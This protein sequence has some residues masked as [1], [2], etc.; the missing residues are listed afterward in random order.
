MKMFTEVFL[1]QQCRKE[2]TPRRPEVCWQRPAIQWSG[3]QGQLLLQESQHTNQRQVGMNSGAWITKCQHQ[4]LKRKRTSKNSGNFD[5]K[6]MKKKYYFKSHFYT[7]WSRSSRRKI[8]SCRYKG[9]FERQR[10]TGYKCQ[11][12]ARDT[13]VWQSLQVE[14]HGTSIEPKST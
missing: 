4:D 7:E 11:D 3:V 9:Y 2:T 14:G 1:T 10:V 13:V 12:K 8:T 6:G 5:N